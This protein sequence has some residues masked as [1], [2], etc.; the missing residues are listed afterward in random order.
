VIAEELANRLNEPVV[1]IG[2]PGGGNAVA[3]RYVLE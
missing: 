1:V 2:R 3:A